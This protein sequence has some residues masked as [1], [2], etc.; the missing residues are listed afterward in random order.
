MKLQQYLLT[1]YKEP[2]KS[3]ELISHQ[4]ML[5]GGFIRRVAAG[6]YTWSPIGL[7]VLSKVENIVR[8]QMNQNS[9][10]ELKF[11]TLQPAALWQTSGRWNEYGDLLLKIHDRSDVDFCYGP[12]NEES[13][14]SYFKQELLSY[15]Q[16]PQIF[17][18]IQ[19][20]FRDETRPRFGVMRAREFLMKDAYSFHLDSSDLHTTYQTLKIC[21]SNIFSKLGLNY[22]V[23]EADSGDIGGQYSHE[24]HVI[25]QS[26][27]DTIAYCE[28]SNY[29]ANVEQAPAP[30]RRIHE[31]MA[32]SV[33][34]LEFVNN[35][36]QPD[37]DLNEEHDTISVF[38]SKDLENRPVCIIIN[39]EDQLNNVKLSKQI[40]LKDEPVQVRL[41]NLEELG[42]TI[43]SSYRIFADQ[44]IRNL[45]D[46]NIRVKANA[47]YWQG[48]NLIALS[49]NYEHIDLRNVKEGELS[50]DHAGK[51]KIAKGIEVGHIFQLGDKYSTPFELKI[52]DENGISRTLQ[53]GCYGIGVS[54]VVAACIEQNHDEKGIIW[55]CSIA[56]FLLAI[57]P[58]EVDT[59]A[60]M[61]FAEHLYEKSKQAHIDACLDDRTIRFGAKIKDIELIGVP[62]IAIA[63]K[64]GLEKEQ[65]ELMERRS[66]EHR[67]LSWADVVKAVTQASW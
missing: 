30:S 22:K 23:V 29:A 7:K 21:Y 27:E 43:S 55:P 16:L 54:R 8:E 66:G 56:P 64:R 25:A 10:H 45:R 26:G 62:F 34:T 15:K 24:F 20:K 14:C 2:P 49:E 11:P 4:L 13:I 53:M 44:G 19:T 6:L 5:R 60:V 35:S 31:S 48:V 36:Q 39:V 65:Y 37:L 28:E 18:Q 9:A 33:R 3:A 12:T 41:A 63:S 47:G 57:V 38:L 51:L 67:L 50:P 61:S 17:Y 59:P 46:V 1:T 58:V 32:L 40:K 42:K 52:P